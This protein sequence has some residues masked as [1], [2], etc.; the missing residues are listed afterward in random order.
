MPLKEKDNYRLVRLPNGTFTIHSRSE[1]ETFHPVIG[2]VAEAQSLYVNQLKLRSRL[3]RDA[4]EFVIWDVGLGAGGNVLTLLRATFDLARPLRILSFDRT[5][6]PLA[7]A[8]Q[9][10]AH[11]GYVGDYGGAIAELLARQRV[12]ITEPTRSVLW[13]L[14]LGDFPE[15]LANAAGKP[16]RAA[17]DAIMFDAFSPAKNPEMWTAQLFL[18]LYRSLDPNK[19]C[20]MSTYSRS[21][22]LRVTLLLAGF[23]VGV[24]LATGEKEET[25]IAANRLEMLDQPLPRAWLERAR[26]SKSAEPLWAPAYRQAP[27]S[28]ASWAKLQEHPQFC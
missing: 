23:Y 6:E 13:E 3:S 4:G 16:S 28:Q 1:N 11:L 21:T 20:S 15:L 17:P 27:L 5:T 10:G 9:H 19:G 2:P 12:T 8:A 18:D 24:G 25:T 7:F 14:H 26:N 22:M